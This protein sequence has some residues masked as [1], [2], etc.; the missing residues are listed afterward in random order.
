MSKNYFV[1]YNN[2]LCSKEQYI[3]HQ[4]NATSTY[5]KGLS[6]QI[7]SK[8]PY[9]DIYSIRKKEGFDE[10]ANIIVKN[11]P[12]GQNVSVINMI[13]QRFPG[14][15]KS[16]DTSKMRVQWFAE[17]LSQIENIDNIQSIAFP[18]QIGCGLARGDWK[19]YKKMIKDFAER[20]GIKVVI[21]KLGG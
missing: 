5:G 13:A 16:G 2:L 6:K 21:Y 1:T 3:A 19:T 18:Y 4:C 14:R 17:C 9:A 8:Y 12:N 10:P 7:F 20:S 15:P 11:D